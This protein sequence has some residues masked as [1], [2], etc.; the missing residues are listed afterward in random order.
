MGS[1]ESRAL[2]SLDEEKDTALYGLLGRCEGLTADTSKG[3]A[4]LLA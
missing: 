4:S 1:T 3:G 2:Q